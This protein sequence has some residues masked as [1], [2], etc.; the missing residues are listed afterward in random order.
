[1]SQDTN[2][3]LRLIDLNEQKNNAVIQ[4][5]MILSTISTRL[6]AW[7]SA[8]TDEAVKKEI[9]AFQ[10]EIIRIIQPKE[11]TKHG[12]RNTADRSNQSDGPQF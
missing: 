10:Q 9:I 12:S 1:M 7:A 4:F 8:A 11:G 5:S 6:S 2:V 3:M